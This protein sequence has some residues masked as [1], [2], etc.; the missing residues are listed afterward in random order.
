MR[1]PTPTILVLDV[2]DSR[3]HNPAHQQTVILKLTP[4]NSN[5]QIVKNRVL[6]ISESAACREPTIRSAA[7]THS[8]KNVDG[9]TSVHDTLT[10]GL[11]AGNQPEAW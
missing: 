7:R 4:V 8:N 5:R 9:S 11:S 10:I 1:S 3:R 6:D 2:L